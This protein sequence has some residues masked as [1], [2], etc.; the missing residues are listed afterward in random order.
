MKPGG[1]FTALGV[2]IVLG[3]LVWWS[4]KHPTTQA[5]SKT[6]PAPKLISVDAKQIEDIRLAKTGSDPIELAN[7][8]GSWTISKP[9]PMSADSD[10]VNMLTGSLA[11]LN[12]DRM[13]DEHPT[14]LNEFGLTN[15]SDE[16]DV[17]VKGGKTTKLLLGSDTPAG[18]GV[19]A[20][21]ESDP[22]VYTL[23]TYLKTSF[24]KTVNDLRDKR[25]LTF[26]QDKLTSVAI[27][28]KAETV[29]FGKNAQGDWQIVKPKPMR[30][31]GLKV[32]DLIRKLKDA[33]MDLTATNYD[34]KAVAAQFASGEKVGTASTTDNLGTQ[35]VEIHK[36]NSKDAKD[37]G[38]YAKSSAVAGIYKVAGDIGDSLGKSDD[39]Y[40]N[41]KLFDFGFNDVSKLELNGTAY[42]KSGDKWTSGSTAYDAGTVQTVI[43]KLRDLSA[44]KFSDKMAGTQTLT[45]GVAYGDNHRMEKVTVDKD[46]ASYN[47][48]R[49]GEPAVYV[50]EA[51]DADDLQK[52][53]SGIK[54]Q[55]APPKK[56]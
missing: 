22:K 55:Q 47:A 37:S 21:L 10:A 43:D 8:A 11:T 4:N 24:D 9:S 12:A 19:Y 23:P 32:D 48:Q 30:A 38:Y 56:K 46:G 33:K 50:I 52:A 18:T 53:I 15:P 27:T 1:L 17:T 54:Q 28:S 49:D 3:G 42:Q 40:R 20:K 7:L 13:I 41:K 16:I 26:N 35:T 5:A 51:K 14:D 34:P 29:E 39:D 31:D 44:S 2:L 6:P 25:L 36:S 45:V